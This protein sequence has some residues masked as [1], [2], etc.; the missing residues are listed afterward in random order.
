M[1]AILLAKCNM[2]GY[3]L[4]DQWVVRKIPGLITDHTVYGGHPVKRQVW[5]KVEG[6]MSA[7]TRVVRL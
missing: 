4:N 3:D 6:T 5:T 1:S 7:K 2:C